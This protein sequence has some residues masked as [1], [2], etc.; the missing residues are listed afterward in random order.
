MN[1]FQQSGFN[2]GVF[3]ADWTRSIMNFWQSTASTWQDLFAMCTGGP[4]SQSEAYREKA[5]GMWN[6]LWSGMINPEAIQNLKNVGAFSEVGVGSARSMLDGC[7]RFQRLVQT[8]M[9]GQVQGGDPDFA[10]MQQEVFQSWIE[11]HE[12]EIQPLLRMPQVGLTRFYQEKL[13]LFFD[14]L[15]LYQAALV[16][17]QYLLSLPMERSLR[18]IKDKID[19]PQDGGGDFKGMYSAWIKALEA[20]YMELF[21]SEEW[22][23]CLSRLV[24]ESASFRLSRN[25]VL[26]DFMQFLPVPTNKD[27][28]DVY[29]ELYELKKMVKE[30]I[31]KNKQQELNVL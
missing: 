14:R 27:M 30:L 21:K 19:Q 1:V 10:K 23:L 9:S 8:I 7:M 18:D 31:K 28:D 26:M 25:E 20:R 12:K 11:F 5:F 17:F 4:Q 13:N 6:A 24:D 2:H 15:N 3:W 29:K 22:C 16:E